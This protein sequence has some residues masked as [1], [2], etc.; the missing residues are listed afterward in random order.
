MN[1]KEMYQTVCGTCSAVVLLIK[2]GANGRNN[3]CNIAASVSTG[4]L[5]VCL[6]S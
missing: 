6:Y 5:F 4:L 2:L 3:S 1:V